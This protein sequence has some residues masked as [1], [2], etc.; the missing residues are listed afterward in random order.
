M[1]PMAYKQESPRELDQNLEAIRKEV[2]AL[3]AERED[4]D[5]EDQAAYMRL[6]ADK[7]LRFKKTLDSLTEAYFHICEA[8]NW[9]RKGISRGEITLSVEAESR[10]R[11]LFTVW[12]MLCNHVRE[13]A[14]YYER[15][16]SDF[17]EALSALAQS[18]QDARQRY[19]TWE[20]PKLSASP[21]LRTLYV[22]GDE[23]AK[24][25]AL[26]AK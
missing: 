20:S 18:A 24:A 12:G 3:E 10:F 9:W 11:S 22:S 25:R 8:N 16:G 5:A 17:Q 15:H 19:L 21:A 7:A 26:F 2:A 13:K 6:M 4:R 23:L 14:E 1:L